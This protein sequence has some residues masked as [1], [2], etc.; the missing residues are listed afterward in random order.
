MIGG[1]AHRCDE[2]GVF[3]VEVAAIDHRY[4]DLVTLRV[5]AGILDD[6][7]HTGAQTSLSSLPPREMTI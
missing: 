6:A 4:G 7:A 2:K 5:D 3:V 1:S